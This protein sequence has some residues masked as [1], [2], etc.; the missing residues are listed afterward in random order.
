MTESKHPP[1]APEGISFR[2]CGVDSRGRLQPQGREG[3]GQYMRLIQ[4]VMGHCLQA[5]SL[6]FKAALT[7]LGCAFYISCAGGL[8]MQKWGVFICFVLVV[9][10]ESLTSAGAVTKS[11]Y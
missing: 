11:I 10:V 1:P 9:G 2:D 6:E 5:A 4:C 3:T 7:D 8:E